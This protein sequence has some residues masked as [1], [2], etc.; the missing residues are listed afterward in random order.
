MHKHFPSTVVARL[1]ES[2]D[3]PIH[4][5]GACDPLELT[6]GFALRFS[7]PANLRLWAEP[8][9]RAFLVP[10]VFLL[11]TPIFELRPGGPINE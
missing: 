6:L 11:D 9:R 2:G 8:K 7:R 10:L 5:R 1:T 4:D 3:F